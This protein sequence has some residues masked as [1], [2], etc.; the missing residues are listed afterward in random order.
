MFRQI[1]VTVMV[2]ALTAPFSHA[3][4]WDKD[5]GLDKVT[6]KGD[7]VCIG[8]SLKKMNGAN[9]QCSLYS[10][11]AI[12]FKS[13]DGTLWSI[14]DNAKGHDIIRAH[15]LLGKKKATITGWIYPLA[16]FI[17][18]DDIRVDGISMAEIQ[19]EGF[20]E[21][22]LMAERLKTRKLGEAPALGHEH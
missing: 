5:K 10:Q 3:G 2:I 19:K 12:G 8:C 14:V 11:H 17:E 15:N 4:G 22:I 1:I 20:E 7:L 21:D 16:H 6:V 18:I 13:A 9:A